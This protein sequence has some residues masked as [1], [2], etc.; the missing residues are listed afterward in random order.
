MSIRQSGLCVHPQQTVIHPQTRSRAAGS[1][2]KRTHTPAVPHLTTTHHPQMGG[3]ARSV[4]L[5]L[6]HRPPAHRA[7]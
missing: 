1:G 7:Q 6:T 4:Q 5:K 3:A 2:S